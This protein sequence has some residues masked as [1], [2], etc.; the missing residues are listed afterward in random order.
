MKQPV[1]P[2]PPGDK[3]VMNGVVGEKEEMNQG[4][5]ERN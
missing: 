3:E 4:R 1:Q 5:K 2:T